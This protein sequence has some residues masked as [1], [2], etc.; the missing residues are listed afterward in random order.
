MRAFS[1]VLRISALAAGALLLAS[2]PAAAGPLTVVNVNAPAVN[3]VFAT[4]CTIT[5]TDSIGAIPITGITGP[6]RLQSRSFSGQPGTPGAGK[7]GYMYRVD[8]TQA[9]AP[10]P[11]SCVSRLTLNFGPIAKLPYSPA[12]L[13]DIFV[14]TSGGL[15]TIGVS[16]AAQAG[17]FVYINFASPVCPGLSPAPGKT[18]FFIGLASA[19]TPVSMPATANLVPGLTQ[20]SVPSRVPSH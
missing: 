10:G 1:T 6:A 15:G 2:L 18:S 5:V 17:N 20:V 3:C 16:S 4:S 8:L 11:S 9:A 12:G 14:I 13:A 7:T 19:A